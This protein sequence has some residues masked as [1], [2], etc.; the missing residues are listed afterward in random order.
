MIKYSGEVWL[1]VNIDPANKTNVS[2]LACKICKRFEDQINSIK[3][4]NEAWVQDGS[5]SL[6]LHA[7]IEYAEGEPHKKAYGLHLKEQGLS[8]RQ[9]SEISYPNSGGMLCGLDFMKQKD[10]EK[11][12]KKFETM[13]FIVK[14]ELPITEFSK[15][16]ELELGN[17]YRKSMS[18]SIMIDFIGKWL[19]SDLKKTTIRV[20][21]YSD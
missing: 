19:S 16:L 11:T 12:K 2:T 17:V 8:I 20:F 3:N 6:L 7:A 13:Y 21:Q 14:E 5:K 18:G 9:C 4:F 1:E 15:I 10:F